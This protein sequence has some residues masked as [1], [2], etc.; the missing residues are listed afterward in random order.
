MAD[1]P[2]SVAVL[3]TGIMGAPMARNL[4]AAGFEVTV[5]N[6]TRERADPL[7]DA[8]ATIADSPREAAAGAEAVI[9]M[10][11]DAKAVGHVARQAFAGHE[12]RGVWIQASTVGIEAARELGGLAADAGVEYVDAPVLGTKQPAEQGELIVLASGP[13]AARGRCEPVFDAI[14]SKTW[15][16]GDA[17]A[18]SRMKLVLN[19]WLLALTAGL[20]ETIALAASLDADPATFL[21]II[22]GAPMGAPYAQL[23]GK[24]MIESSL[25]PSFPL[26]LAAKDA[27][28]VLEAAESA[29]LDL[30]VAESVERRFRAA[31][32]DHGEEDMAAVIHA[33]RDS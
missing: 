9:T 4:A 20:A 21:E 18:G 1:P 2:R 19:N 31:V 23:K 7:A 10:L 24:A 12:G 33:V 28:L 22:D 30:D 16:L 3:G 8:G 11:S 29:G 5:W 13:E 32:D 17:G 25:D 15:W 6:R 27:R 26:A 14:G